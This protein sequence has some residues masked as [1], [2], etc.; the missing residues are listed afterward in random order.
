MSM[1]ALPVHHY[2]FVED[3]W[4]PL[5]DIRK[6]LRACLAG[7]RVDLVSDIA[8]LV[9]ELVTNAYQHAGGMLDLRLSFPRRDVMRV[10]V[11]DAS[12]ESP[13]SNPVRS[14]NNPRGRGLV[15]V[16]ALSTSW[17]V[18]RRARHKTVWAEVALG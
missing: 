1:P 16:H 17:G 2:E 8:L 18:I 12:G 10:E 4:C 14:P 15:L 7:Q 3:V 11:D 13:P 6:W 5:S 9:T